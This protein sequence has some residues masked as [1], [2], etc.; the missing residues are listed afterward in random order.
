[1]ENHSNNLLENK[2]IFLFISLIYLSIITR[3]DSIGWIIAPFYLIILATYLNKSRGYGYNLY[4][5]LSLLSIVLEC[6]LLAYVYLFDHIILKVPLNLVWFLGTV[7]LTLFIILLYARFIITGELKNSINKPPK[8][9]KNTIHFNERHLKQLKEGNVVIILAFISSVLIF[10]LNILIS[11]NIHYFTMGLI[12]AMVLFMIG[13]ML[14]FMKIFGLLRS[15][16]FKI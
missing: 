7:V 10:F 13:L 9:P 6:L 5:I 3:S 11:P 15:A 8:N 4:I 12:L 1:M 14:V 16:G 2:W